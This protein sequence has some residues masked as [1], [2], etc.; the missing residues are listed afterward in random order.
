MKRCKNNFIATTTGVQSMQNMS[1][2]GTE[3]HYQTWY[4]HLQT[5]ECTVST[6]TVPAW[7]GYIYICLQYE[8]HQEQSANI[9][10]IYS[11]S[12]IKTW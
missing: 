7:R 9:Y 10:R 8:I 2:S 12:Y 11:E 4:E 3:E 1:W 5:H 6:L